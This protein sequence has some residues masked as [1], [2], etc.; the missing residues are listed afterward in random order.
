[1][2]SP[3]V[4]RLTNFHE[5]EKHSDPESIVEPSIGEVTLETIFSAISPGT[6]L[7][8]FRGE[9]PLR[10]TKQVYPRLMGYC[11][12]GRI[13]G[14]GQGVKDWQ[15]GNLVMT[16]VAHRSH[17]R[18]SAAEIICRVPNDADLVAAS[19]TYLFHLGY[20]AC[21]KSQVTAGH[22]VAVVGLGTLGSTVG[23]L[24]KLCGAQVSGFSNHLND[25]SQAQNFG[26]SNMHKKSATGHENSADVVITT[27]NS[28]EDWQ[29]ALKLAR[30]GGTIAVI[31]F[32]GRGQPNASDNPLASQYFYDKQLTITACGYTPDYVVQQQDIRFTLKR[33]CEFLLSAILADC[34]PANALV[35]GIRNAQ[36]LASIYEEMTETRQ[37]FGTYV[38]DWK[39]N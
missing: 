5:L 9:P 15:T 23:A 31:G 30:P 4:Y 25:E 12:I 19:T 10:P 1:M 3:Y 27:S 6:E 32:P 26:F 18:I 7:A 28:W 38:L 34:L 33:N 39:T 8:A 13:T 16:H 36:N 11:N 2:L 35:V 14:V 20:S 29:L 17:D 22:S 37:S 24:A 21:L